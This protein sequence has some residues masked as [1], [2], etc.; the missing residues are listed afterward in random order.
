MQLLSPES[1]APRAT[2]V[3]RVMA[4]GVFVSEGII[5]FLFANQGVGRFDKL[6]FPAPSA[7][8]TAIAVFEIVGGL[9]LIGGFYTR[10]VAALFALEMVVAMLTTKLTLYLGTSPLA[11]PASEPKTGV[12][13][14]LHETRVDYAQLMCCVFLALVGAGAL[15]LDAR[16]RARRNDGRR[17][18][19][20]AASSE[21]VVAA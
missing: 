9:A 21:G 11:P 8:A 15:S 1:S 17:V 20:G 5:K 18:R 13:A 19:G 16:W 6:G 12:W 4:G 10:V 14:L 2:I 3:I 7:T